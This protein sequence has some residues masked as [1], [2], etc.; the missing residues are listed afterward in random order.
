MEVETICLE[1]EPGT[2]AFAL[3]KGWAP[4]EPSKDSLYDWWFDSADGLHTVCIALPEAE[5][6]VEGDAE[7]RANSMFAMVATVMGRSRMKGE[8]AKGDWER[9]PDG[10]HVW[11]EGVGKDDQGPLCEYHWAKVLDVGERG[12]ER[13]EIYFALDEGAA[14]T[15]ET[16]VL[17]RHFQAELN[18]IADQLRGTR[19]IPNGVGPKVP[20]RRARLRCADDGYLTC[21][22]PLGWGVRREDSGY[23]FSKSRDK[24]W[25]H[26]L[27]ARLL[28]KV[29]KGTL[30]STLDDNV[31]RATSFAKSELDLIE[32]LKISAHKDGRRVEIAFKMRHEGR[33]ETVRRWYAFIH[34]GSFIRP[35][36]RPSHAQ[37][38]TRRC[39]RQTDHGAPSATYSHIFIRR[40][41]KGL[42]SLT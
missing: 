13:P 14:G 36:G 35:T 16:E 9:E 23:W 28:G 18:A 39:R 37:R 1:G 31:E 5:F 30:K 38:R 24:R 10:Y 12:I 17:C 32:P 15:P 20:W 41:I 26:E 29:K 42:K 40:P 25:A 21:M 2:L 33:D 3:P 34:N 6:M 4:A 8:S 27:D 11:S 7:K 22:I 19:A